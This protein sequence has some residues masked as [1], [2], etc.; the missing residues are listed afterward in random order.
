MWG[1]IVPELSEREPGVPFGRTGVDEAAQE[2][3]QALVDALRLPV[4]PW[5]TS[6]A[7]AKL[8]VRQTEQLLPQHTR[9]DGVM[10]ININAHG[11]IG[12][13]REV[14]QLRN[15]ENYPMAGC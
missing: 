3:L 12:E 14:S 10:L 9:E 13:L 1:S 7:H 6:R 5:V 4:R 2:G 8:G 15:T 11:P